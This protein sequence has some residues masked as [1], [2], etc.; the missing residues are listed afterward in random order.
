MMDKFSFDLGVLDQK[1]NAPKMYR[2][3]DVQD[4]IEKVAFDVVRFKDSDDST[5]LWQIE[6]TPEGKVIVAI[7]DGASGEKKS[8]S[9]WKAIPDK[10]AGVQVFHKGEAIV[11][12]S[13][14]DYGIADQDVSTFCR[15]LPNKLASDE[16]FRSS[17]LKLAEGEDPEE[18]LKSG[19]GFAGEDPTFSGEVDEKKGEDIL[20]ALCRNAWR[21][22]TGPLIWE[23]AKNVDPA[24][25]S[26]YLKGESDDSSGEESSDPRIYAR[27]EIFQ[28]EQDAKDEGELTDKDAQVLEAWLD[29]N[30]VVLKQH[31]DKTDRSGEKGIHFSKKLD[32]DEGFRGL[33]V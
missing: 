7:Y 27:F 25:Y 15:W 1:V 31:D 12:L 30:P 11:R 26:Q 4:R 17:L 14:K 5:K 13:L 21:Q 10:S 20:T 22:E 33:G 2:L 29:S 16:G 32:S 24:D 9:E 3:V 28:M 23:F 8:E 19:E 18:S 6:D